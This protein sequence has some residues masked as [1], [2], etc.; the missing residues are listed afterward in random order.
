MCGHFVAGAVGL[1]IVNGVTTKWYWQNNGLKT[2][3]RQT[4]AVADDPLYT[5]EIA[6]SA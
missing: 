6:R 3:E 2:V 4:S 5:K 1:Y